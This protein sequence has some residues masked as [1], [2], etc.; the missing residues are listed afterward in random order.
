M[1]KVGVSLDQAKQKYSFMAPEIREEFKTKFMQIAGE[2]GLGNIVM[3]TF[4]RQMDT[5]TQMT[6]IDI[7]YAI[8]S[9]LESPKNLGRKEFGAHLSATEEMKR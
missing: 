1:A 6:A 4:I 3:N 5:K 2:F 9:I 8:S 7:V